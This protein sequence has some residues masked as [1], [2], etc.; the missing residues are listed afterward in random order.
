[1]KAHIYTLNERDIRNTAK[2]TIPLGLTNDQRLIDIIFCIEVKIHFPYIQGY[3]YL[4]VIYD[5]TEQT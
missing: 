5:D 2:G 3:N 4:N 1:M